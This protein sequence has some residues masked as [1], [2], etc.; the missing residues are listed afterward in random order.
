MMRDFQKAD[1]DIIRKKRIIIQKLYNDPDIITL[2][3]NPH[4]E[5]CEPDE[6]VGINIYSFHRIT[7]VQST[8]KNFITFDIDDIDPAKYN[9]HMKQQHIIFRIFCHEDNVKTDLGGDRHD[10]LAFCIRDIFN[11]SNLFG[12]QLKLVYNVSSVTDTEYSCRTLKFE[13]ITPNSL[14]DY[15]TKSEHGQ[16][17]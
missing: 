6:Y 17:Y 13:T 2:L 15:V 4:L 16:P 8:V 10:L 1:D 14:K 3:N 5:N 7:P 11:W 9:S 12:L